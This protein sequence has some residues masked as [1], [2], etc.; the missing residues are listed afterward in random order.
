MTGAEPVLLLHGQPGGARDWQ[1]VAAGLGPRAIAIDRPGWDGSSAPA[2]LAGNARAALAALDG[3]GARRAVI[4]GHSF[5]AAVAAWLAAHHP[6]RVAR[7]VLVSPAA[8]VASLYELDRW[9]ATP[10]TGAAASILVLSAFGLALAAGPVRRGLGGPLGLEDRYLRYAGRRLLSPRVWRAFTFE[11]RVL[12]RDLPLLE[13]ALGRIGAPTTIVFGSADRI[14][15]PEA[16][17]RLATQI[18]GATLEVVR[19]AGHL[20]PL[21]QAGLL[22]ELIGA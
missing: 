10:V 22:L 2:D 7:L 21:Q 6:E 4:V 11:Q 1:A 13:P 20:L 14:V 19:G 17:R 15:P 16:P 9:L 3:H 8:N 5:G 18:P 12:V